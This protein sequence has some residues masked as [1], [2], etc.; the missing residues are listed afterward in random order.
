MLLAVHPVNVCAAL[1]EV[2]LIVAPVLLLFNVT[3]TFLVG[4]EIFITLKYSAIVGAELP[5]V[6]PL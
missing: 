2:A 6:P 3:F 1:T 4:L 5:L